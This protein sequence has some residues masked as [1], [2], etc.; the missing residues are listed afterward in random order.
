MLEILIKDYHLIDNHFDR[1]SFKID[2]R[3]EAATA[4]ALKSSMNLWLGKLP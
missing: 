2:N 1:L 4:V 3:K